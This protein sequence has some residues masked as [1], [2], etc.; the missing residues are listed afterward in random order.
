MPDAL[1]YLAVAALV[2]AASSRR[3]RVRRAALLWL[4]GASRRQGGGYRGRAIRA[5][6]R[7]GGTAAGAAAAWG[8]A[9]APEVTLPVLA[10]LAGGSAAYGAW[11]ARE[12]QR[13]RSHH[14]RWVRPAYLAAREIAGWP[15]GQAAKWLTVA[16]DRSAVTARLPVGWKGEAGE[17]ARLSQVLATRVGIESPV[18]RWELAGHAPRL[19]LAKSPPP[20]GKT[21]LAD[22]LGALA[23][24]KDDEWV[25]GRGKRGA[26]VTTSLSGDSPHA[27]L[28]MG[29]GAGKSVTARWLL[30]QM[31]HRGAIG[32]ILDIKWISHMWADGLP[33]VF[34][35]RRPAEIHA[36]LL[37]LGGEVARRNEVALAGADIDGR[38]HASVGPR[39]IVVCEEMNAT[40]NALRAHWK[41]AR[42][43]GD[44]A[45][46]PALDALDAASFMGRQVLVNLLYIA[47]RLS[48]RATGGGDGRENIGVIAFGR[49]SASAWRMLAPDYPMPPRSM[50]PGRIQVVSDEVR[51][52]QAVLTTAA[53]ARE[54]ALSGTVSPLPH[55]M[56]GAPARAGA[57]PEIA[58]TAV[59]VQQETGSGLRSETALALQETGPVSTL[60]TLREAV[61]AGLFG[62][63][64]LAGVRTARHR[65]PSFPASAGRDG[66]AEMY[67]LAA[68]AAWANS[69]KGLSGGG[70]D[71]LDGT[72]R[73]EAEARALQGV[74][75]LLER[76]GEGQRGGGLA[77]EE[78]GRLGR[79]AQAPRHRP[80]RRVRAGLMGS[81]IDPRTG[82]N[83]RETGRL[84]KRVTLFQQ[85]RAEERDMPPSGAIERSSGR[86][87]EKRVE[88][89]RRNK[90]YPPGKQP[91]TEWWERGGDAYRPEGP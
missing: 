62:R 35:A 13:R 1:L 82:R 22:A 30:A 53:E 84:S 79:R 69:R 50:T 3:A 39:L 78:R 89:R 59:A 61:A 54:Y 14:R 38:V 34:I 43:A 91:R 5:A 57:G 52:C 25:W 12:W 9:A 26:W 72:G 44:P 8:T 60:V 75:V 31:L 16:P 24:A 56:P 88:Q 15:D 41:D 21:V 37:W 46:S 19:E 33:N 4:S 86:P 90:L 80:V 73:R 71:R 64:G 6:R 63:L 36:A 58:G 40:A 83:R 67:D 20:P 2:A 10:V 32:L 45:R 27:A 23:R 18:V 85:S 55:G 74:R 47:Q 29:S 11:R 7:T 51:E 66:T 70:Q 76:G 81:R 65:D 48:A 42:E 49:Y 77:R 28:S 17:Q 68:L 87:V